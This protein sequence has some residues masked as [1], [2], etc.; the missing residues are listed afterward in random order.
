MDFQTNENLLMKYLVTFYSKNNSIIE[1]VVIPMVEGKSK[2]SL[3]LLEGFVTKYCQEKRIHIK[4]MRKR[5]TGEEYFSVYDDYKSQL[6]SY[7][8]EHFD[9]FR[10][11]HHIMFKYNGQ[12]Y[13]YTTVGQLN[14]FRW[15]IE[16][17]ILDYINDHYDEIKKELKKNK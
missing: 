16:N 14:F 6:I 10:R 12:K 11:K 1:K 13:L 17:N 4:R 8:K 7:D 2:I 15:V 5:G 9:P 3:R